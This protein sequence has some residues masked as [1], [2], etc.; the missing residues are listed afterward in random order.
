MSLLSL[1]VVA[2][3]APKAASGPAAVVPACDGDLWLASIPDAIYVDANADDGGDG[4]AEAPLSSVFDGLDALGAG[5]TLRMAPGVYP[6]SLVIGAPNASVI[7]R[8][9][10]EVFIDAAEDPA[11]LSITADGVT[12]AGLVIDGGTLM[13]VQNWSVRGTVLNH[14]DVR[15]AAFAGISIQGTDPS[16]QGSDAT[17]RDTRVTGVQCA[18]TGSVLGCAGIWLFNGAAVDIGDGSLLDGNEGSGIRATYG[19][20]VHVEQTT[21]S[22]TYPDPE[23][24][25]G[26]GIS[27][28]Y[29]SL[30]T[31]GEGTRI[32]GSVGDAVNVADGSSLITT[33]DVTLHNTFKTTTGLDGFGIYADDA[34]L[35]QLNPGL[36]LQDN[37]RSGYIG[38]GGTVATLDGVDVSNNC[39]EGDGYGAISATDDSQ[40]IVTGGTVTDNG[41]TGIVVR[42]TDA[43]S[44]VSGTEVSGNTGAGIHVEDTT[45]RLDGVTIS[46]TGRG[47]YYFDGVGLAVRNSVV[48]A[49]SITIDGNDQLGIGARQSVVDLRTSTV[50]GSHGAGIALVSSVAT[51]HDVTVTRSLRNDA[52]AWGGYGIYAARVDNETEEGALLDLPEGEAPSL[53]ISGGAIETSQEGG[54]VVR[55][56]LDASIDGL[57]VSGTTSWSGTAGDGLLFIEGADAT[58]VSVQA[59]DSARAGFL[60]DAAT[61]SLGGASSSGGAIGLAVQRCDAVDAVDLSAQDLGAFADGTAL[62][63][64]ELTVVAPSPLSWPDSVPIGE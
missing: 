64:G 12:V 7:G 55:D 13:G 62:C 63:S 11:G 5:G 57:T 28:Q 14:M 52:Q 15:N 54:L 42:T 34:L 23:T 36:V 46:D 19:S 30:I 32:T 26:R 38:T 43:G 37:V 27:A 49:S 16:S 50:S 51:L 10:G 40:L 9:P 18:D 59:R 61:G 1:L 20:I 44:S 25:L 31:L 4:S 8:C 2:A 41:C 21:I 60:F 24:G 22:S 48:I 3:C 56:G 33:G 35:V 47:G 58:A 17:V 53:T 6:G 45:L 39:D 29:Q